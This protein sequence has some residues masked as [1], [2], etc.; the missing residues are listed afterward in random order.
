MQYWIGYDV[1][2]KQTIKM[3]SNWIFVIIT[4]TEEDSSLGS[5]SCILQQILPK[6][7][8]DSRV[9]GLMDELIIGRNLPLWVKYTLWSH[10]P[11]P[12][13]LQ[14]YEDSLRRHLQIY[15]PVERW[16][17]TGQ[18]C[19]ARSS[20]TC[21]PLHQPQ[22]SLHWRTEGDTLHLHIRPLKHTKNILFFVLFCFLL[23]LLSLF[24][25]SISHFKLNYICQGWSCVFARA[26]CKGKWLEDGWRQE[27][28]WA[29]RKTAR[30]PLPLI[31]LS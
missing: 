10:F 6:R 30:S 27:M 14:C 26:K 29:A 24:S 9:N 23:I 31:I 19:A 28:K 7:R 12:K 1:I 8:R 18:C 25:C 11:M 21:L 3:Q 22:R 20:L 4:T 5:A 17:P 15:K 13:R 16:A 2:L